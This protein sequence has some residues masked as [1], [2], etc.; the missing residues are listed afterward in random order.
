VHELTLELRQT[1]RALRRRPSYAILA[2]ATLAL[3]LGATTTLF[4]VVHG[5]LLSPLPYPD[6]E[7]IVR[8]LGAKDGEPDDYQTISYPNFADFRE[9][10]RSFASLAAY[11]EWR[12][13]Y[14]GSGAAEKL[15]GASVNA[16]FFDVLGVDPVVGRFFTAAEDPPGTTR[17]VVLS[18][19]LWVRR[20]GADRD[21]I[22]RT[23]TLNGIVYEVVGVAPAS[24]EDPVL[25]GKAFGVPELWRVSPRY[26]AEGSSRDG[27]AFTAVGRLRPGVPLAAAQA[28]LAGIMA[29]LRSAYPEDN[30]GRRMRLVPLQENIVAAARPA[31]VAL[32]GAT[33]LLLLISSANVANLMLA[34]SLLRRREVALRAA[35]GASRPRLL[36]LLVLEGVVLGV[37]GGGLGLLLALAGTRLVLTLG[38]EALPRAASVGIDVRVSSFA[39]VA[40]LAVGMLV[41]LLP[42]L[43]TAAGDLGYTLRRET[44]G[45]GTDRGAVRVRTA[46]VAAEVALSVVLVVGAGLLLRTLAALLA[47]D[48]G[49]RPA[50][51]LAVAV[52][53]PL[54]EYDEEAEVV[55]LWQRMEARLA[56]LPGVV[57]VGAVDIL[58]MSGD[59]NGMSFTIEG[60][61]P[62]APG[63]EPSV[64]TRL[65][66]AGFFS[67]AG[68]PVV[69]GRAL[70]HADREAAVAV[71][72]EEMAR[73]HFP[74]E[75]PIGKRLT[76]FQTPWVVVGVVGSVRQFALADPAEG[77]LYLSLPRAV[78][79]RGA[80]GNLLIRTAGEAAALAPAVR[81]ALR[82]VE[83]DLALE[84]RPL[85]GVVAAT[86][87]RSRLQAVLLAVFATL[88][89][90][91]GSIGIYGVVAAAVAARRREL[92][93]RSALGATRRRLLRL[94]MG[95]GMAPVAT[96]LLFGLAGA[97][98]AS[99][100]V[101]RFL[102]GVTP[103]DPL[104][105]S[106]AVGLL[107]SVAAF[108]CWLPARRAS[109]I[110]PAESLRQ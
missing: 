57:A 24:L 11:D 69:R 79:F 81:A 13:T 39:A 12:L 9:Q 6:A 51:V 86:A 48:P 64:E 41:G 40:S 23:M 15:S 84:A 85:P 90:L 71:V 92:G 108:A 35:L 87:G 43:R 75:D 38:G 16:A 103:G 4:A 89:A 1:L 33:V 105:Y 98:T 109:R 66:S 32:L 110:D 30:L 52:T 5:V 26:F 25:S 22:G 72:D 91:L 59:F 88:A 37:A 94:V 14:T 80:D 63:E 34:R 82:E 29:G 78:Q 31:L 95:Q 56:A 42:A 96:G 65:A 28:E 20:F 36:R 55:A 54:G 83:P 44:A 10:T 99:R 106:C 101:A 49:F 93:I 97:W 60:A 53:P 19:G 50:G 2:I 102:Y 70:T 47:I 100:L 67:A 107:V 62:P 3:G 21:V 7:R 76:V 68:I 45:S 58:P 77:T 46:L 61:P 27:F 73:R 18:H 104:T 17:A 8:V 74:G